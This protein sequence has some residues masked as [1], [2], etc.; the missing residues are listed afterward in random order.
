MD[1]VWLQ[2]IPLTLTAMAPHFKSFA[3]FRSSARY[4]E[5]SGQT[6]EKSGAGATP[7]SG[8]PLRWSLPPTIQTVTIQHRAWI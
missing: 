5:S 2:E 3:S 7:S 4:M 6:R 1:P 8:L